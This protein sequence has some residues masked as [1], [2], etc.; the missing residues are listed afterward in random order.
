MYNVKHTVGSHRQFIRAIRKKMNA[1][2]SCRR[3][4]IK[5]L[6]DELSFCP[7]A[8]CSRPVGGKSRVSFFFN[9]VE[10][11]EFSLPYNNKIFDQNTKSI[12]CPGQARSG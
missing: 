11:M 5:C 4:K 10:K 6:W 9:L 1:E 3:Y 7:S 2:S 8:R 12:F